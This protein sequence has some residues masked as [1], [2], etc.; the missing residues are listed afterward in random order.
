MPRATLFRKTSDPMMLQLTYLALT[1]HP[2]CHS[3]VLY[4]SCSIPASVIPLPESITYSGKMR[5][6]IRHLMTFQGERD[7]YC[8]ECQRRRL[9]S[10]RKIYAPAMNTIKL[11]EWVSGSVF[12][13]S[14]RYHCA[15]YNNASC[16]LHVFCT[17]GKAYTLLSCH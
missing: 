3:I 9:N 6:L 12:T 2:F 15:D 5:L 13:D 4:H 10:Y 8:L 1:T 14:F 17:L 7:T 11:T 16:V